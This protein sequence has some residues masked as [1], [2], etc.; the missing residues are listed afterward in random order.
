MKQ[1]LAFICR[2]YRHSKNNLTISIFFVNLFKIVL[3]VT[4]HGD[5]ADGVS[6]KRFWVSGIGCLKGGSIDFESGVTHFFILR[7]RKFS[8]RY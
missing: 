2:E 5:K 1:V 8:L 4:H 3:T 7:D 6:L